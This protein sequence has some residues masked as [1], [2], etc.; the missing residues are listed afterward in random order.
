MSRAASASAQQPPARRRGRTGDGPAWWVY[1]VVGLFALLVAGI[2][3]SAFLNSIASTWFGGWLPDA[4]TGKWYR[5]ALAEFDLGYVLGV[6][7][8]VGLSVTLISLALGVPA[9]YALARYAF[10]GRPALMLLLV[11]PMMVPP[12]TYGIPLAAML[13]KLHLGGK[14]AGVIVANIVPAMPFVVLIMTPFFEQIDPNLERAARTLGAPP[15]RLFARVLLPIALPG[16]LAAG[17][18]ILVRAIALFELTFLVSGAKSQ[19]L[20]VALYYT[21]F[22]AGI[23]PSQAIDAMAVVYMVTGLILLLTALRFINPVNMVIRVRR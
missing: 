14:L 11:L 9:A 22:A 10:P 13:Y 7:I 20:V 8:V 4:Y 23:R 1:A 16:V 5:F 17:L 12:I 3:L 19:T 15:L 21:A 18:L 6:T 2:F